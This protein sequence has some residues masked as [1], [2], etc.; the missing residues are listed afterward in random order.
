MEF[1]M[2]TTNTAERAQRV[3]QVWRSDPH[4]TERE[5]YAIVDAELAAEAEERAEADARS[6]ETV[7]SANGFWVCRA[8]GTDIGPGVRDGY[9]TECRAGAAVLRGLNAL[10]DDIGGRTRRQLIEANLKDRAAQGW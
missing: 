5:V 2:T 7:A 4:L 8:C 3:A 6:R 1:T 9:C 10:D